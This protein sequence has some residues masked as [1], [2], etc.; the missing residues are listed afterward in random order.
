MNPEDYSFSEPVSAPATDHRNRPLIIASWVMIGLVCLLALVPFLGFGS[1]LIA[2]P[3]LFITLVMGIIVLARGE[4]LPGLGILLVSLIVAPAFVL[5]AP[6]VSSLLGLGGAAAALG[7]SMSAAEASSARRESPPSPPS[8]SPAT[9]R[10][11]LPAP[12][13]KNEDFQKFRDL[14][15]GQDARVGEMKKS[16]LVAEGPR[17]FLTSGESL[18]LARRELVQRENYYREQVFK[19]IARQTG[20]TEKQVAEKFSEMTRMAGSSGRPSP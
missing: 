17:G 7:T 8:H 13:A 1:W 4:T 9:P 6:F 18:D 20:F 14:V 3:V 10:P 19:I 5:V 2:S 12:L 15:R 16:A 11:A